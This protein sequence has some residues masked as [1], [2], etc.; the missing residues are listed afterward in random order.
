MHDSGGIARGISSRPPE[1]PDEVERFSIKTFG[2]GHSVCYILSEIVSPKMN[3]EMV[4]LIVDD[5]EDDRLLVQLALKRAGIKQHPVALADGEEA[6]E[7]L[8]GS[9]KFSD[10]E[11]YPL[12]AM[13]IT[14]FI[15]PRKGGVELLKWIKER[16]EFAQMPVVTLVGSASPSEMR[17]AEQAGTVAAFSKPVEFHRLVEELRDVGRR[18][19]K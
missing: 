16:P 19:L 15:M 9:G 12:P 4:I 18:F 7:Y 14:D 6:I 5:E 1:P 11:K 8:K 17:Q 3:K 2:K 10:R 13:I